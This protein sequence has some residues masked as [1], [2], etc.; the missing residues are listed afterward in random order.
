MGVTPRGRAAICLHKPRRTWPPSFV[1]HDL[2]VP[3]LA[4]VGHSWGAMVTAHLPLAGIRPARLVLLD[5]PLVTVAGWDALIARPTE[6]RYSTM[7]E[8]R[9]AVRAE[10]LGWTDGDV[11]AKARSLTE[12]DPDAVLAVLLQNGDWDAGMAAVAA[13]EAAGIPIWLIRGEEATGGFIADAAV[14]A[15]EAQLGADRVITIV[16]GPHSPQ[17]THPEATLVALLRAI[18]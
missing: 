5:P 1:R 17:R 18:A 9:A 6:Q 15:I 16:D 13:P 3:A 7:D 14:P 4:V 2:D 8:A 12:F 11:E 10:N